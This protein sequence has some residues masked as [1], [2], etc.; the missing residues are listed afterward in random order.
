MAKKFNV[1]Q[2]GFGPMG[3]LVTRLLIKRK[4]IKLVGVVDIDPAFEGKELAELLVDEKKVP[5][6]IIAQE[7]DSFLKRKIDVVIIATSSF[8]EKIAPMVRDF[9][10]AGKNVITMCEQLSYPWDFYPELSSEID[11]LAKEN[12]VTVTGSGINPG[13]LMDFLPIVLTAPCET[14]EKI[15][16]TRM[17]NSSRRRIPF[18]KKIGTN[19]TV[20]E[21]KKK[22]EEKKI[23]GHVGLEESIQMIVSALGLD[24]DEIIE[25]PPNPM[26]TEKEFDSPFGRVAEGYVRGLHSRGIAK[27]KDKEII[28]LDFY[29]YAGDHEEYDSIVIEGVPGIQQ[30]IIGGVHGDIGTASMIVNLIPVVYTA[31][32]GLLTMKDLPAARNT[33]KIMKE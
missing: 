30:K 20:G 10:K 14:V 7:I 32:P 26:L 1:L 13:Y 23:T 21:F 8:F 2:V 25:F 5:K 16:V 27:K 28:I 19:L 24:V 18:Q 29:A 15:H 11:A 6:I 3:Q 12:N 22:I 31:N 4:N 9:I 33:A 17:M